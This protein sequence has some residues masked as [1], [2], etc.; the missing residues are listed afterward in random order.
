MTASQARAALG[1]PL[2]SRRSAITE[3]QMNSSGLLHHPST[4]EIERRRQERVT[5]ERPP[6]IIMRVRS[7]VDQHAECHVRSGTMQSGRRDR[8]HRRRRLCI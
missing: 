2:R 4:G 7:I 5:S 6:A 1:L 8:T 3:Y